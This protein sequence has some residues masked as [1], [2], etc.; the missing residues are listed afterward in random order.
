VR[1]LL[2]G[3]PPFAT[4]ILERLA[5][6]RHAPLALVTP[7]DRPRG[8]GQGIEPSELVQAARRLG[9]PVLQPE[10]PQSAEFAAELAALGPDVLVVASYGVILPSA[11]L[12][13]APHGALNV[14]ASLL[15]RH[16][17]ASPVQAAILCGDRETGVSVQRM[18]AE[19]DAG[20][21]LLERRVALGAETTAPQLLAELAEVGGEALLAALDLLE[22][23][24]A[25]FR[26]Q[27]PARATWARKIRKEHGR[28]DFTQPAAQIERA[29]RALAGWPGARC[30]DPKGRELTLLRV[31]VVPGHGA[32]GELL[33]CNERLVVATGADALAIH[34]LVPAGKRPM[35]AAE[36]LRGARLEP[37]Q[38]LRSEPPVPPFVTGA[39]PR[40]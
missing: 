20:D 37:G 40:G 2:L 16:R 32:P 6:S 19:L 14:H 1:T 31:A 38:Y 26:P 36:F 15:P 33:E 25:V 39:G 7:P 13:L 27:D 28:I 11:L 34:E 22:S 23:G 17:G 5:A 21:V 3:S 35:P 8:R 9:I 10:R 18:A 4:P 24:R 12:E 30:L 29:V